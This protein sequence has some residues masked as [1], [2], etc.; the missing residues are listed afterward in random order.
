MD[1][2]KIYSIQINGI[3]ESVNAVD[4]LNKQLATLEQR[5]NAVQARSVKIASA[6]GS[7]GSSKNSLS[8]E[9]KLLKQI[10]NTEAK[11]EAYSKDI[12]QNYLAAKDVLKETLNDQKQI[13]AQ[14]RLQANNY[15]NTMAGL[16]EKLAD[17]KQVMQTTEIGSDMFKKFTSEANEL[18]QKLKEIEESY[19][20][21]GRNV[22][23][24]ASAAEGFKKIK[25]NVGEAVREYDN[26]RK[27]MKE[28]RQEEMQLSQT[29][30]KQS[31]EYKDVHNAI[32][33][34]ESSYKDLR[35]SSAFMD[36]ML[37]SMETLTS[38]GGIGVGLSS[39]FGID[40]SKFNE[41]MQRLGSLLV[42]LKS[43][44]TLKQQWDAD[45][46]ILLKPFKKLS[47]YVD[48]NIET[49]GTK[50]GSKFMLAFGKKAEEGFRRT[51]QTLS[52]D[53]ALNEILP[54]TESKLGK[55]GAD[56]LKNSWS[57][58]TK[59]QQEFGYVT[60]K[61]MMMAEISGKKFIKVLN[62]ITG[63]IKSITK[64]IGGI[65]TGAIAMIVVPEILDFFTDFIKSLDKTKIKAEQATRELNL[66]NKQL[67][68]R[69]DLVSASYLRGEINDE[70][71]LKNIY[72]DQ[73]LA[74]SKQIE[75]LKERSNATKDNG[76]LGT[77]W[78]KSAEN[79]EFTGQK[80]TGETK[81]SNG[82]FFDLD[83]TVKNIN[84]VE[85][86]W[87]NCVESLKNGE[88][89]LSHNK[90]GSWFSQV[91]VTVKDT[92]EVMRGM[93]N[94]KLSDFVGNF[95]DLNKQ[96][97]TGKISAEQYA[98]ELAK[99]KDA[100]DNNKVLSSVIANLDQ[101]IPDDKVREAVQNIINEI[102][103]LDNAFNMTSAQQ[104]HYW[105]QVRIDSMKEGWNKAKAQ[106]DENER[107][108]IVE[109]GK[110]QEQIDL[111]HKKYNRQRLTAQEKYNKEAAD[112]AKEARDKQ[113]EAENQLIALQIE[114]MKEGLQKRLAQ[115]DE[116]K[117]LELQKVRDNKIKVKELEEQIEIKYN[118]KI[119]EE[120]KKWAFDTLKTYEDLANRIQQ[121]NRATFEKEVGV[122]SQKTKRNADS[123]VQGA[124]YGMI[125]PSSYNNSENLEA[126]YKKVLDI[127]KNAAEKELSIERERLE[128]EIEYAKNEEKLRHS[129]LVNT[130]G[131]E[132][133]Q[134]LKAGLITQEQY[135]NLIENENDAHYAR[136]NAIDNE[137]AS[138]LEESTKASL[139]EQKKL[140]STYYTSIIGDLRK[141]KD[142]VDE[143]MSKQPVRD[144]TGWGVVNISKTSSNY[145]AALA[146]YDKLKTKI[147]QKQ[148]ELDADLKAGRINPEDFA[149]KRSELDN[150][151]KAIDQ[152]VKE[153]S[154][155]QKDLIGEFINS[156]SMYINA[157][158]GAVQE[159][160]N[161]IWDAQDA[162][163]EKEMED[164]E[165]QIDK[166]RELYEEQK[167]LAEEHKNKLNE[168]EDEL[169]TA[170]GD[171]RQRL[172]D[173]LN[174][175][176]DAQRKAVQEQKKAE[177]EQEKLQKKK[178]KEELEQK[179]REQ[180]RQII[181]AI[182][183]TALAT[184]NG[185]ATQPF[186]P[187]GIAMGALAAALGAA[188][189]AI[190]S[191]QKY[192]D[193]GVIEGKSHARGGVKVLGGR[194][195][196]EGGEFITNKRTTSQNV[197]LLEYINSKKKRIDL[198]DMI[199]FYSGSSVKRNISGIK[200]KFDEGGTLPT[201]RGD[202]DVNDRL[203]T[204]IEDYSN[205]PV[206]V[207]VVDI[208][209]KTQAVNEVKVMAGLE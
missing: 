108:E 152:A 26:Y 193:G 66:L 16:K 184:A 101:Y 113:R 171:R 161:S 76:F 131:G 158:L 52:S 141:D 209:D 162:A 146:E 109:Y 185:L 79:L 106:I 125:T 60:T 93:G 33:Q 115:L 187:V 43:I 9:D 104:V 89:Y 55:N 123:Q 170:R 148:K 176:M 59:A 120:R 140:Y 182:I 35:M 143:V 202:I 157:G 72:N 197:D 28:L 23:N 24:Y 199:E 160:M 37:D 192:A 41:T 88:D 190:I 180:K 47:E 11:I 147:V 174:A 208:I 198:S 144:T 156:I 128:K 203:V 74:L 110:T 179:K 83:V 207:A 70:E 206:Q 44:E 105:N 87:N 126:Y 167:N 1:G 67:E 53:E 178:E 142:K 77:G 42:V 90:I 86:A 13:A 36:N 48:K 10:E 58:M 136:M 84:E 116:E 14:E 21:F 173:Q 17:I 27:A 118:R 91:A 127:R 68:I 81:V 200:T 151:V 177:K 145:K 112:K 133:V 172:I 92:E 71:Y 154:E 7:G 159:I 62:G 69:R 50:A 204:A 195:E 15:S 153:V 129:R 205:R 100:M 137:Y 3:T 97:N 30:G 78:F 181:S 117:R 25:V 150:E 155:K 122:A 130:D 46:S 201:L 168:I 40:D 186:V 2:K 12:Y 85:K 95:N 4:S 64:A 139:E 65:F 191:S 121:V 31:K 82:L 61:T 18:T 57:S 56:S 73:T 34:L 124:G 134:Q 51:F 114:N 175:E 164:L 75:L 111:I 20:Q 96:F 163:Y 45:D 63:A 169:S 39:L 19:G 49:I 149:M 189:I 194:A 5:I 102:Y 38:I 54:Y 135:D 99:L 29:L 8:E 132:Y 166:Q 6:S 80:M 119:S 94:I 32:K 22:G 196:V 188:Q 107:Y 138:K 183:S 103:R 165:K 98:S